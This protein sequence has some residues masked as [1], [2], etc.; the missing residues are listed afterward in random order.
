VIIVIVREAAVLL[1]MATAQR[2]VRFASDD[3]LDADVLR[4]TIEVDRTEH[5]AMIGNRDGRLAK[6]FDLSN[7]RFDLIGA[8][9][10]TELGMQMQVNERR[11]HGTGF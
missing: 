10:E 2:H 9:E 8:V 11:G 3:G 1:R 5:V 6:L 4:F 7:Q